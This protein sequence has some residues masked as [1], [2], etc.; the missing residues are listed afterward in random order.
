[1]L[2]RSVISKIPSENETM[3]LRTPKFIKIETNPYDPEGHNVAD[4]EKKY[5]GVSA[6][7]RW[8][9]KVDKSGEVIKD[10]DG[11]PVMESNARLVKW[12]DGTYQVLVGRDTFEGRTANLQHN[13]IFSKEKNTVVE[14]SDASQTERSITCLDAVCKLKQRLTIQP[15]SLNSASHAKIA[16]TIM[17]KFRKESR[18]IVREYEQITTNP[19]KIQEEQEQRENAEQR[20]ERKRK[21]SQMD[22]DNKYSRRSSGVMSASFLE[23]GLAGSSQYDVTDIGAIKRGGGVGAGGRVQKSFRRDEMQDFIEDDLEEEEDD[24][25]DD[26]QESRKAAALLKKRQGDKGKDKGHKEEAEEADEEEDEEEDEDEDE[27]LYNSVV[28]LV[29]LLHVV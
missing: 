3:L 20:K 10:A 2:F 28:L 26:W 6:V 16:Q 1:V 11:L 21:Q 15:S 17:D 7:I 12:S 4:E 25:E 14:Q 23:E 9:Y 22:S 24:D 19:E 29:A 8:R 27:V 18:V 13:Y 5:T